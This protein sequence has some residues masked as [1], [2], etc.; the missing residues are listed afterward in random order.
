[1]A[2][3]HLVVGDW[4]AA[5]RAVA[6]VGGLAMIPLV[7]LLARRAVERPWL[8][9]L[10][11][12]ATALL[13]LPVL[14][15]LTTMTDSLYLALLLGMFVL[16]PARRRFVGGVLGGLAYAVRPEALLAVLGLAAFEFR[17]SRRGA[18]AVLGGALLV[19]G[20][21]VT[22]QG[23]W[24]GKWTLSQKSINL[25]AATWQEAEEKVG[26][27]P[28]PVGVQERLQ[29]FGG[30][31]VRAYPARLADAAEELVRQ[32]G[33]WVPLVAVGGMT[34]AALPLTAGLLQFFLLPLSFLAARPRY[35]LPSLPFLWILSAVAVDRMRRPGPAAAGAILCLLGLGASAWSERALYSAPVDGDF[36][37]LK[38]AGEALA[39]VVTEHDLIF[40]RKPYVAFYAGARGRYVPTG[41]YDEVLDF[42]V[43]EE[44]DYLVVN[45]M[46]A[47][48]L[49]PELLPLVLDPDRIRSE[50]RLVPVYFSESNR[51]V[52]TIVYRVVRP[53]GPSARPGEDRLADGI[54]RY[55]RSRGL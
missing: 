5:A 7:W 24:L 32:G 52:T 2:L 49:R 6:L 18:A 17:A 30:A 11:V 9:L 38:V 53:G 25:A 46:V 8:R 45:D 40:D 3:A 34:G 43:R 27:T 14:Y 51:G 48:R 20:L 21:Y 35:L 19:T 47:R 55:L 13:P 41:T 26:E 4:V 37:E 15:S 33:W 39:G 54:D 36:T 44:G 29:R 50:T 1:V 12:A 28:V 16:V 23:V 22:A 42:V 31:T 10:P